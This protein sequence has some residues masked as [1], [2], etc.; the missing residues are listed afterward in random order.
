MDTKRQLEYAMHTMQSAIKEPFEKRRVHN[1][2]YDAL[3]T[4]NGLVWVLPEVLSTDDFADSFDKLQKKYQTVTPVLL[5]EAFTT[6][7]CNQLEIHVLEMG[8]NVQY[9]NPK[10]GT[11]CTFDYPILDKKPQD[12]YIVEIGKGEIIGTHFFGGARFLVPP[13]T[14]IQ[15]FMKELPAY[16]HVNDNRQIR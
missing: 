11:I 2:S 13:N 12:R 5:E 1:R 9:V 7:H 10:I 14:Q 16:N 8:R 4:D 15:E 3:E 6:N